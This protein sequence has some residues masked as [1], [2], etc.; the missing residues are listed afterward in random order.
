MTNVTINFMD[1][2]EEKSHIQKAY[3]NTTAHEYERWHVDV[4]S[5]E[6]VNAFNLQ[7]LRSFV[8]SKRMKRCLDLACGNGRLSREL[9][10]LAED[11]YGLDISEEMLKI[12]KQKCPSMQTALGEVTQMPYEDGFFDLIVINGALH[13]FFALRKTMM[14]AYRVLAPGGMIAILGEP[15]KRYGSWFNPFKYVWLVDRVFTRL[16]SALFSSK[17]AEEIEPEAEEFTIEQLRAALDGAGFL[18]V[19]VHSYDYVPRHEHPL[20]L[21]LYARWLPLERRS[22]ARW[23]PGMGMALQAFARK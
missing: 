22:L 13:H 5:A 18:D 9:S 1:I 12:A 4:K 20:F 2:Y 19:Q 17:A 15:N 8:G 7:Q 10:L 6:I 16:Y 14:E 21:R 11:M 3:Y 23:M